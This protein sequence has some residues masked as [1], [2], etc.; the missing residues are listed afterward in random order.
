MN[1][2]RLVDID[3]RLFFPT[4]GN[5]SDFAIA[6]ADRNIP[7]LL[8]RMY[9]AGDCDTCPWPMKSEFASLEQLR[10]RLAIA[11]YDERECNETWPRDSDIVIELPDGTVFDMDAVLMRG[12][13]GTDSYPNAFEER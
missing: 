10:Q 13:D 12:N 6:D 9:P 11:L 7:C 4:G 1:R 8:L 3:G 5:P 2:I